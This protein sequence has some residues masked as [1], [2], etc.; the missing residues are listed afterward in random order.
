[1][2]L[3]DLEN[4]A[5]AIKRKLSHM[6]ELISFG[7]SSGFRNLVYQIDTRHQQETD[8]SDS[9]VILTIYL[10]ASK[11]RKGVDARLLV[12]LGQTSSY[13]AVVSTQD[14]PQE[15]R[16]DLYKLFEKVKSIDTNVTLKWTVIP[17]GEP[18]LEADLKHIKDNVWLDGN[19]RTIYPD[20]MKHYVALAT[21]LGWEEMIWNGFPAYV[22]TEIDYGGVTFA[23]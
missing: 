3:V 13:A 12:V 5:D 17:N 8:D 18:F 15:V 10:N 19:R 11:V 2:T 23:L 1:M 16:S 22:V 20:P 14:I 9:K 7:A 21:L 4:R 6:T